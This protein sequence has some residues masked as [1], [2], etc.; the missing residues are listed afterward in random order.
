MKRSLAV[1]ILCCQ[2]IASSDD[3]LTPAVDADLLLQQGLLHLGDGKPAVV[4]NVAIVGDR[5]V[6]VGEFK[7]G[8]VKQVIDC[9]G[10]IISPGFID[11]HNHSDRQVL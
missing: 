1:A 8:K 7:T 2:A 5:I 6:A 11:L 10:L 4:G 9:N 3:S